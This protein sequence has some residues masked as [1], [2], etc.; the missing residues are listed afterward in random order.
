MKNI[1]LFLLIVLAYTGNTQTQKIAGSWLLT[2]VEVEGETMLPF[3][4]T[5]FRENGIMEVNEMEVGTWKFDKSTSSILMESDVDKDFAGEQKILKITENELVVT[6]N[7]ATLTY[8]KIDRNKINEN[9][10]MSGLIGIWEFDNDPDSNLTQ[11]ITFTEPDA[12]T[13]IEKEPGMES[14]SNGMW[15]FDKQKKMLITIG[16][17]NADQFHGENKIVK[18][19]ENEFEIEFNGDV[20]TAKRK[21]QNPIQIEALDFSADEFYNEDG[22][23]KYYEEEGKLPW[24]D[25]YEKKNSLINVS[26]LIYKYAKNISGTEA[27]ENKILIAEVHAALEEEEFNIDYIFDGYDRY[28]LPEDAEFLPN[29]DYTNPLYPLAEETFRIAGTEQISVPAGIFDCTVLEAIGDSGALKKLWMINDKPGIYAKVVQEQEG[30]FG[31]F[32]YA[33]TELQEIKYH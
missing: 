19:E 26:Q 4:I 11:L 3:Y 25:W 13:L 21:K 9:N 24:Q 20:F 12:F 18:L 6:K 14:R 23:Y 33:V 1:L 2:K 16:L 32:E 31:D 15:I 27:F 5:D 17:R 7:G 28:N 30:H 22:D 8:K 10:K 29:T